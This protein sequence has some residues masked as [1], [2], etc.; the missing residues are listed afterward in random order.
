MPKSNPRNW[1]A[2][3]PTRLTARMRSL[4]KSSAA[5][6]IAFA[7]STHA[8][9][10][11][12]DEPA[13]E[14]P[15]VVVVILDD[16]GVDSASDMYPGLIDRLT[17]Q[18]GPSGLDHPGYLKIDGKP[19]S[20]PNIARFAAEGV[21]F[22]QA[23]AQPFC[24]PT[25]AS[26]LTGLFASKTGVRDYTNYLPQSTH[27][28]AYDLKTAG[29]GT[30]VFG[31]WH[32]AGLNQYPGLL[33]QQA[34]FDLFKGNLNGAISDFWDY[35]YQVQDAAT[36][37]GEFRVEK[38]PVS[39]LP[40]LSASTYANTTQVADAISWITEQDEQGKPW[41]VWLG[42]S[43]AHI[44]GG[45]NAGPTFVPDAATLDR[46]T[47][48]EVAACHGQFGSVN[49][50]DCSAATLN[51]A[52]TNSIDTLF[53]KLIEAI[54]RI[55]P[56]TY[57]IVMGDN[58]T[59]MYGRPS[60]NFIDN[61]YITRDGRAKGTGYE[62][63]TRIPLAIRGPGIGAARSDAVV[64]VADL[65]STILDFARV[66]IPGQVPAPAGGGMVEIDSR[67]LAPIL[68]DG[69]KTVRDPVYDYIAAETAVP[70]IISPGVTGP[71]NEY[72]VATRNAAFKV[73]C[74]KEGDD[75]TCQFFN[76]TNDPLEEFPLAMPAECPANQPGDFAATDEA[77]N[78][79]F[80]R[81]AIKE[82]SSL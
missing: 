59:P 3:V 52:M 50:G 53:G 63:G 49:I 5:A 40:G 44:T 55:D 66:P 35:A 2:H 48:D 62:S 78:F 6:M 8:P 22:S 58:G 39:T 34:N 56:N 57:V 15:N 29:Y 69:A 20:T 64:H 31:K 54:D 68:F 9:A 47:Y 79:C 60:V 24:S 18:Y 73:L 30:A 26:M 80:L 61:M 70:T 32:M 65:F 17:Q 82:Q 74:I 76:L 25:R 71:A 1:E 23:W 11:A 37:P 38:A 72:Q 43:L 16:I 12:A 19:G 27:S 14:R 7:L 13:A 77:A 28:L 41:F 67:S 81:Q 10:Q 33:P 45:G 42:F 36:K 21:S 4:A 75:K 46:T 51:R